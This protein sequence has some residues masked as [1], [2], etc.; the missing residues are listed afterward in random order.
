MHEDE[1][2]TAE[3]K[4]IIALEERLERGDAHCFVVIAHR[5]ADSPEE[6]TVARINGEASLAAKRQ[7][8]REA[9][10]LNTRAAPQKCAWQKPGRGLCQ[11][12][13]LGYPMRSQ[14]QSGV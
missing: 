9:W 2:E 11:V 10:L 6:R 14:L 5:A 1:A 8:P 13:V 3:A 12:E 7:P 4:R